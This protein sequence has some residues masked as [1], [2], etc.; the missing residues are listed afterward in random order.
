MT[1]LSRVVITGSG[2]SIGK[3]INF[4]IPLSHSKLDVTKKK[5]LDSIS[6]YNPSAILHLASVPI[7]TSEENPLEAYKINVIAT[8]SIAKKAAELDIPLI[9]ISTGAIFNGPEKKEFK[10][11]DTPDPQNVY[12]QTKYLAE[13][14]AGYIC[15]KLLIIR[16]GWLFGFKGKKDGFSGFIQRTIDELKTN[17]LVKAT[18]DQ[19]G[20]PTYIKDFTDSLA[21]LILSN[22]KGIVHL[23]NKGGASAY[24]IVSKMKSLINSTSEINS[25]SSTNSSL[26][27]SKSEVLCPSSFTMRS[28]EDAM[29]EYLRQNTK[30]NSI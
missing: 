5:D 4:G 23:V 13:I 17:K 11:T 28:W 20:S 8:T 29:S 24:D 21:K 19:K 3:E 18:A 22:K 9:I 26:K 6:I 10:E 15:P 12:G 30:S 14:L 2:G 7:K 1:D 16:T 25:L 27:R